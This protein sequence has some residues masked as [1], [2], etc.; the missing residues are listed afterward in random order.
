MGGEEK[1]EEK[2]EL[3][4]LQVHYLTWPL[5]VSPEDLKLLSPLS[6]LRSLQL[7]SN[8]SEEHQLVALT[9]GVVEV[10]ANSMPHLTKLHFSG[11]V[12]CP[13]RS[14]WSENQ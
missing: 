14:R 1:A 10:W 13:A 7:L 6:Q 4:C 3:L 12:P 2:V 8:K 9:R 11:M 5:S